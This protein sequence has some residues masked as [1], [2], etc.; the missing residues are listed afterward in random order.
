MCVFFFVLCWLIVVVGEEWV[1]C[2]DDGLAEGIRT[3]EW[4][5]CGG[6]CIE[7][8]QWNISIHEFI[9]QSSSSIDHY[10]VEIEGERRVCVHV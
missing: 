4:Q 8:L 3:V 5:I 1:L 2:S 6:G 10:S 7:V 9:Q